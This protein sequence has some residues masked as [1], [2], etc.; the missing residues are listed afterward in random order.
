[1]AD[2]WR[3]PGEDER[4]SEMVVITKAERNVI[5]R[6]LNRML[7][8]EF[9]EQAGLEE[10]PSN[11]LEEGQAITAQSKKRGAKMNR[12]KN[13]A[14]GFR[15]GIAAKVQEELGLSSIGDATPE[16][17]IRYWVEFC[18]RCHLHEM[19][20]NSEQYQE[21]Q[22]WQCTCGSKIPNTHFGGCNATTKFFRHNRGATLATQE[23]R[24]IRDEEYF[25]IAKERCYE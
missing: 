12:T 17:R 9:I 24:K 21:M 10:N 16:Q 13:T 4:D 7:T 19:V 15:A 2:V 8:L 23:N 25:N 20:K 1:M 3:L 11:G 22:E 14:V 6:V 18:A 5:V